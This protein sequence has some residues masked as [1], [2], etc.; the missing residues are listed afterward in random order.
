M[1]RVLNKCNEGRVLHKYTE[2]MLHIMHSGTRRACTENCCSR[3]TLMSFV[4]CFSRRQRSRRFFSDRRWRVTSFALGH[5]FLGGKRVLKPKY[6]VEIL[7][8]SFASRQ[9]FPPVVVVVEEEEEECG[10]ICA[11]LLIN[12]AQISPHGGGGGG[13]G[14]GGCR[15]G[16]RTA[17]TPPAPP[18]IPSTSP[19]PPTPSMYTFA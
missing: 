4:C 14:G 1:R 7:R 6:S 2:G 18:F 13:G 16:Q 11:R 19:T 8:Q 9:F 12:R 15:G 10:L 17:A 3:V 5:C